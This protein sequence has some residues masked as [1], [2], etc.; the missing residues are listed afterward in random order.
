VRTNRR[1]EVLQKQHTGALVALQD[2]VQSAA[3][4]DERVVA[5]VQDGCAHKQ[6]TRDPAAAN[7]NVTK[8]VITLC[9]NRCLRCDGGL[10]TRCCVGQSEG[11]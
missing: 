11:H 6:P 1:Q 7:D 5:I 10:R 9:C 3:L 2:L 4:V 8:C